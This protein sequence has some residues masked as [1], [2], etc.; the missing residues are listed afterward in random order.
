MFNLDEKRKK[1]LC[2]IVIVFVVIFAAGYCLNNG[3][4]GSAYWFYILGALGIWYVLKP[5]T[6]EQKEAKKKRE[7]LNNG[8]YKGPRLRG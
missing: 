6:E 5:D 8:N 1:I 4:E 7:D 3:E 2:V